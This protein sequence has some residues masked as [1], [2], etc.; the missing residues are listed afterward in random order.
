M[1]PDIFPE[2][3]KLKSQVT[4]E[5]ILAKRLAEFGLAIPPSE[6]PK[7]TETLFLAFG[8]YAGST[9][10]IPPLLLQ[11]FAKILEGQSVS[12]V[13]DPWAGFGELL[14]NVGEFSR[15]PKAL[16]FTQGEAEFT[17]GKALVPEAEWKLG[18]PLVSLQSLKQKLDLVVSILP[19]GAKSNRS[20]TLTR[21]DGTPLELWDDL[22]NLIIAAATAQLSE[23][24]LGLFVIP[25]SFFFPRSIL[26]KF[27]ALGF[28]IE[29]ALALPSGSFAPHTNIAAYLVAVRKREIPRMFVA[30]LS[31]DANTN[32]Q[33]IT[34]LREGKE[35]GTLDLGRLVDPF[36]FTGLHQIRMEER[37]DQVGKQFGTSAVPLGELATAITLGPRGDEAKFLQHQN[38]IFVPLIGSSDVIDSLTDLT[39]KPQNYAQVAIDPAHSNA[40]FV[41]RF[42]NSE[43]GKEIRESNK[44]GTVIPKLNLR[45]LREIAIF[46]P[47]PQTQK[48]MLETEARIAAEQNTLLGL[49]NELG[50]FHRELW[51][52]PHALSN[53]NQRLGALSSRLSGSLKKHAA[54]SLDQWFE[55]LPFP[56]ASILRAWQ[57]TPTQDFKAKH[58][59]LLHFFEA[60]AEFV[61]V[62][63]L[64]AFSPNEALFLPHKQK[65]LDG[66]KSQNLSFT[67]AT[68]GTWK[69][70]VEYLGKQTRQLLSAEKDAKDARTLCAEIFADP[71]LELPQALSR[72]E[73]ATILS[74]TNK[75]RNDWSGHGGVVGQEVAQLRNEQLL[76]EVEKLREV[77]AEVWSQSQLIHAIHCRP[78]RGL[79]ENEVALLMGSNSEFLKETRPMGTWLDVERLY[80]FNKGSGQALKLLPLVQ[81]GPSP[82]SA[83][84]ACYF[85]N[86]LE[87]DGGARFISYHFIDEPDRSDKFDDAADTIRLLTEL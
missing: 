19:F 58:E 51:A 83:K 22:G 33:I 78:R 25:P 9:H 80:L 73:L 65:M 45:T 27:P 49:Q 66:M 60:T 77:F 57:A 87:R 11:V 15:A 5:H 69:L 74:T 35:G 72:K 48:A 36:S 3:R 47:D 38:E 41:A 39:M 2:L 12:L 34:N 18:D 67:R 14:A 79:F 82:K 13:C 63:L 43:L 6:I 59:H 16:A 53:V 20:L 30:Q 52:N 50:A 81:V 17:I 37:L 32:S 61:S 1:R 75:M 84:N 56:L 76:A 64:S 31:S 26:R 42:L 21:K 7:L 46:I 23:T 29:A 54:E 44:S 55:A 85:F 70:V 62:I 4:D 28:G 8:R 40:R 10:Y 68:F 24:G 86:R 71:S